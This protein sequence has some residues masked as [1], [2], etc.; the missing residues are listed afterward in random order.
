MKFK[1]SWFSSSFS[2]AICFLFLLL[3][4]CSKDD[5]TDNS[6]NPNDPN[7]PIGISGRFSDYLSCEIISV[8]NEVGLD[9]YYTKYLNCSGIPVI[10]PS[11]VSDEAL[12]M[13]DETIEFLLTNRGSIR[14][15]LISDGNYAVIYPEGVTI[16]DLPENFITDATGTGVYNWSNNLK[17]LAS[18]EANL[19]CNPESG[20]GHTLVH[21]VGHMIDIGGIRRLNGNFQT[22]LS[23]A[24]NDAIAAGNWTNT[25]ANSNKEEYFAET[26]TI[27]YGVNWIGPEGGDG[28]R[29]NIGTRSQL[30]NY[31][32][33]IFDLLNAN[34]NTQTN[35]PGCRIPVF[36]NVTANCPGTVT[37][38]DGNVYEVV[39][40]GPMCWMKENLKTTRYRDG[41]LIPNVINDIEWQSTSEGAW[42]N[43]ENNTSNDALYGKLYNGFALSNELLCP[44]GWRVPNY[45]E[46]QA[47]ANYAGG[48][49][50]A[51]NLRSIDYWN[52]SDIM[53]TD[54]LGFTLLPSGQR[55]ENG[56]FFGYQHRGS[57]GS[58]TSSGSENYYGKTVFS[59]TNFIFTDNVPKITGFACR[60]IKD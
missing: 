1:N 32:A 25:Y 13:A 43:Y 53:G 59:D 46:L 2:F 31:D 49:S 16:S 41:T 23:T 17:A 48:D 9:S 26:F 19:I 21:E 24:Y 14:A 54:A 36:S 57:L 15:Q 40:V 22:Q 42:S 11:Q 7:D 51:F 56:N 37:D 52:A 39:N 6:N 20:F 34:L 10:A 60:C 38:V 58:S 50:N 44:E 35:I 55:D 29:N 8:P 4:A 5:P 27:Y 33:G 45:N 18:D 47:L 30:Q 3:S 28:W 12:Y